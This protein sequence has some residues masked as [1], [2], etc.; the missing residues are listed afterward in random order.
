[1]SDPTAAAVAGPVGRLHDLVRSVRR[2]AERPAVSRALVVLAVGALVVGAVGAVRSLP[3]DA[4]VDWPMLALVGLVGTPLTVAL[5]ALGYR[6]AAAGAGVDERLVDSVRIS[7]YGTAANLLPIPGGSIVRIEALR[8]AGVSLGAATGVTIAV[9]VVWLGVSLTMA[10]LIGLWTTPGLAALFLLGG[11]VPLLAAW[12]ILDRVGA[13]WQVGAA[14]VAVHVGVAVVQAARIW[15]AV[16]AI[17]ASPTVAQSF[18]LGVS[19]SVAAAAGFLPGGLG[20]R[21]A[22]ATVLGPLIGLT[23]AE[24]FLATLLDRIAGLVAIAVIAVVVLV[25][26][27]GDARR[28]VPDPP[29]SLAPS[30]R[31]SRRTT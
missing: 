3:D 31:P 20:V 16:S 25:A 17:G 5:S 10:G 29:G 14:L 21:E 2:A 15:V 12:R 11:A 24:T 9:G 30:D 4:T 22:V 1:M 7:V 13:G 19:V 28:L 26:T 23:A 6:L 8:R 27:R 18:A